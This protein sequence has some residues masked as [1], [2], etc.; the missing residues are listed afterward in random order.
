M[1]AIATVARTCATWGKRGG[2]TVPC[3]IGPKLS[4]QGIGVRLREQDEGSP[5]PFRQS[6]RRQRNRDRTGE[7]ES[8]EYRTLKNRR[9]E[10]P[11][12]RAV[13]LGIVW[14][15]EEYVRRG[16]DDWDA[17]DSKGRKPLEACKADPHSMLTLKA[18]GAQ[19]RMERDWTGPNETQKE[20]KPRL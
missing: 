4:R 1:T 5:G 11:F 14:M 19:R 3:P 9:G 17:V 13:A 2:R 16:M 8:H 6:T 10:T 15:V 18:L 20:L 12:H 7:T